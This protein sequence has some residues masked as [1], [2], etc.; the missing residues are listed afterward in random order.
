MCVNWWGLPA[1]ANANATRM[2]TQWCKVYFPYFLSTHSFS[3]SLA[4]SLPVAFTLWMY[5]FYYFYSFDL[6]SHI[7]MWRWSIRA[8]HSKLVSF[9]DSSVFFLV[10]KKCE[11]RNT[12]FIFVVFIGKTCNVIPSKWNCVKLFARFKRCAKRPQHNNVINGLLTSAVL[13]FFYA[14]IGVRQ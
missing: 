4:R 13:L 12:F 3:S 9:V 2:A 14:L 8:N 11:C 10:I 7:L 6:I 1:N 5:R